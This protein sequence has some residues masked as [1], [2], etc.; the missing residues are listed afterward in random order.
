MEKI[1]KKMQKAPRVLG[2]SKFEKFTKALG[3]LLDTD[4]W[5]AWVIACTDEE[6]IFMVN[7][8]L[9]PSERIAERTF[10][11]YKAGNL[12]KTDGDYDYMSMFVASYKRAIIGQK[13]ICVEKL[14]D[15]VPGGWQRYAWLLERKFDEWNLRTKSVDETP[16][17]RRLVFVEARADG[18]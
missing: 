17:V 7:Q 10:R 4:D 5:N 1:Q 2:V 6:L 11:D 16:D 18:S 13:R 8:K 12:P 14:K 3:E 9:D 15:D